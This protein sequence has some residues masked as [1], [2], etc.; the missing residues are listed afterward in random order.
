MKPL[1]SELNTARYSLVSTFMKDVVR[2]DVERIV[3]DGVW[4][5]VLRMIDIRACDPIWEQVEQE[6]GSTIH[7]HHTG[8]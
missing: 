4:T 7:T 3:I 8:E 5:I 2:R 1:R 6:A